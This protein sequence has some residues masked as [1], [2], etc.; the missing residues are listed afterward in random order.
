MATETGV[1]PREI[2]SRDPATGE[3]LGRFDCGSTADV[4]AAALFA[5][6]AQPEWNQAGVRRRVHVIRRF[7]RLLHERKAEVAQ[8]ITRESGKPYVESL[9]TD[10][11]VTLETARFCCESAYSFLRPEPVPHGNLVMKA[12]SGHILRE[13]YGVVGV[14]A[15]WNYP[16]SIPAGEA[17][18]ALVT[19]NAVVLKPSEYTPLTALELRALL[20]EAGVPENVFRVVIGDGSTGAALVEASL[21]KL[22]FTGSVATGRRVAQTA[23]SRLMPV[24]LELGGK[25]PMLVLDD[26]NLDVASSAAVWAANVNAGQTC[27]S[28]ERC[29]VHRSRYEPFLELCLSKMQRLRVGSGMLATT[30][31]GPLIHENQIRIVEEHVEDARARGAR[32]LTGGIRLSDL[33]QNFYAPT[34]LANVDHSMRVMRE[35]TFGPVLP[36]MPFDSEDEAVRLANDSEFGLSASIWTRYAARGEELAARLQAGAVMINDSMSCYGI[37]EAPHGGVKASGLGRTHGRQGLEEMV[38][39]KYVDSDFLPDSNKVWWFGYGVRFTAQME[40]FVDFLHA[41]SWWRRI[42]GGLGAIAAYFRDGRL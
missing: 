8:L 33:G 38:R 15:P 18:A 28:V 20:V 5:R 42:R 2:V 25:D 30:D 32:L 27:I 36:V 9:L 4:R 31:V 19:G 41:R 40:D 34:L 10:V 7:M 1:A 37:P 26:A 22:F 17:L 12:K 21:D 24:V 39:G 3:T 13:P 35:E 29:Y 11:L 23:A 16:F 14:I 6:N